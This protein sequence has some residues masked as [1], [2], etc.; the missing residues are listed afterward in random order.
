M[1]QDEIEKLCTEICHDSLNFHKASILRYT[2]R[3]IEVAEKAKLITGT[4]ED[5]KHRLTCNI[6]EYHLWGRLKRPDNKDNEDFYC[7]DWEASV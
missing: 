1:K 6:K 4:C 7:I 3:V 2:Q 5:C